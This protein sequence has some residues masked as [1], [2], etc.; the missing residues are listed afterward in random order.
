MHVIHYTYLFDDLIVAHVSQSSLVFHYF[1]AKRGPSANFNF[2]KSPISKDL[3]DH[4]Q[5]FLNHF[6]TNAR[7]ALSNHSRHLDSFR[8]HLHLGCRLL[9]SL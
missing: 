4:H 8:L 1:T 5:G 2:I 3:G 9:V 7:K 6:T